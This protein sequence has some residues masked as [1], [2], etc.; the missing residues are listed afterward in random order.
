MLPELCR[1]AVARLFVTA[2]RLRGDPAASAGCSRRRATARVHVGMA[3][4]DLDEASPIMVRS[5]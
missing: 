4:R 2:R 1:K 5:G 3:Y